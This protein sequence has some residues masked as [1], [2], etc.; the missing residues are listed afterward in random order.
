MT[1]EKRPERIQGVNHIEN[2]GKCVHSG[3]KNSKCI[4][5]EVEEHQ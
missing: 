2:W 5:P 4:V 3:G 1:F